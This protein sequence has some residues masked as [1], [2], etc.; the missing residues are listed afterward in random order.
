MRRRWPILVAA[1]GWGVIC[2]DAFYRGGGPTVADPFVWGL[3]A[4]L[5]FIASI[6][7][8]VHPTE[9]ALV[10]VMALYTVVGIARSMAYIGQGI[11]SALGV[12][13]VVMGLVG[14]AYLKPLER[15]D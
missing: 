11:W 4:M 9:N 8:W 12:W 7:L 2:Y 5:A 6:N 15:H 10:S 1:I 14:V 3:G 13:L